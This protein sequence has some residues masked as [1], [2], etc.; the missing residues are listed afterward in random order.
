MPGT[1]SGGK[2]AAQR[3]KERYGDDFYKKI[4]SMGG[5]KPTTGGFVQAIPCDCTVIEG[6]HIIRQCAGKIGGHI[7]RR[8]KSIAQ[9]EPVEA[10]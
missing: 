4:G 5:K 10:N 6:K 8:G 2:L 3:N 7:S 9:P 1:L